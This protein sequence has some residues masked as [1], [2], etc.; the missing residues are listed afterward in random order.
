M[1]SCQPAAV[2]FRCI[3]HISIVSYTHT[4]I[5]DDKANRNVALISFII[6]NF[7]LTTRREVPEQIELKLHYIGIQR[8][9]V[10]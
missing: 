4:H 3:V 10:S 6:D 2:Q 7:N 1:A 5:S 9:S 8:K